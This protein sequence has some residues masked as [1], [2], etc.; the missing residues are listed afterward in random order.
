MYAAFF[1]RPKDDDGYYFWLDQM[2]NGATKEYIQDIE[3]VVK[4]IGVSHITYSSRLSLEDI[5]KLRIVSD[6]V[7]NMQDTD[8]FSGSLQDHLYCS[9]VLIVGEW[10]NY[11]PLDNAQVYYLKTS[12]LNL[13]RTVAMVLSDLP[14]YKKLSKINRIKMKGL[15]SWEYVLPRWAEAYRS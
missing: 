1:D 12:F 11:V 10:L 14:A 3:N 13:T 6:V 2:Y 8:A 4:R 9:N 5:A 15:T 7:I